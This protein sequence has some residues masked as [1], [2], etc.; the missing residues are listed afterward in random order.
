MSSFSKSKF[1]P[2]FKSKGSTLKINIENIRK[3]EPDRTKFDLSRG[4]EI[5][6]KDSHT[7]SFRNTGLIN[8]KK[9]KTTKSSRKTIF[10]LADK[11]LQK[12]KSSI[13]KSK[14]SSQNFVKDS[15]SSSIG[16]VN[17]ISGKPHFTTEDQNEG[18]ENV[19]D[20]IAKKLK[21]TNNKT[22]H[23]PFNTTNPVKEHNLKNFILSKM[24]TVYPGHNGKNSLTSSVNISS[25]S[26]SN[27]GK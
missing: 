1:I 18:N 12:D 9:F 11:F 15:V 16:A 5:S 4:Y 17:K 3:S 22:K 6:G 20:A 24:N 14:F 7:N 27:L 25:M 10:Y 8:N 13:D 19:L 23:T 26:K 2:N 21:I